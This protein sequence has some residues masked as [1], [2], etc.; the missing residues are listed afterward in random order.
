[1]V[2]NLSITQC[3]LLVHTSLDILLTITVLREIRSIS[4]GCV[5]D[6]I[7]KLWNTMFRP[8][9]GSKTIYLIL[10]PYKSDY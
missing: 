7:K 5:K 1:M 8:L 9:T 2:N 10:I 6:R 3:Y 4:T